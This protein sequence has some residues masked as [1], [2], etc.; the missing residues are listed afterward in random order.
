MFYLLTF[1]GREQGRNMTLLFTTWNT[2]RC[3][4]HKQQVSSKMELKCRVTKGWQETPAMLVSMQH[5]MWL[6]M[7][8][9]RAA[10]LL[11]CLVR[12]ADTERR[13][14][15]RASLPHGT[16][17]VPY[18]THKVYLEC[19]SLEEYLPST[20]KALGLTPKHHNKYINSLII[21]VFAQANTS[22]YNYHTQT[23]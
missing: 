1:P 6:L 8:L 18:H 15:S 3:L 13:C 7:C 20:N 5:Q 19:S 2:D 16:S 12:A 4:T 22:L 21:H 14:R 17:R 9:V 11:M 23:I 10:W